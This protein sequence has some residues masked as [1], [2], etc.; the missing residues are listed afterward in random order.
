MLQSR[1]KISLLAIAMGLVL[2]GCGLDGDD[3]DIG[4]A[5]A[6][7]PQG[8]PGVDGGDG[9]D[10]DRP[11]IVDHVARRCLPTAREKI[12]RPARCCRSCA[13]NSGD[14]FR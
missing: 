6:Q 11:T 8:D 13:K 7:G 2:T 10:G 3:G 1:F 12:G 14:K 9:G 5:G 4:D